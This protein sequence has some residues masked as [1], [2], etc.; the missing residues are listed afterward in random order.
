MNHFWLPILWQ[1]TYKLWVTKLKW[2]E[3]GQ[4]AW[5]PSWAGTG[6]RLAF[7]RLV[8]EADKWRWQERNKRADLERVGRRRQELEEEK[9][10]QKGWPQPTELSLV[11]SSAV[12]LLSYWWTSCCHY[13][14]EKRTYSLPRTGFMGPEV[15]QRSLF[16]LSI[17]IQN[18]VI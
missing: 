17:P 6:N 18:S 14:R 11:G 12:L 15:S 16:V 3:G 5:R 9:C 7:E 1:H 8:I 10:E 13:L 2:E 4:V